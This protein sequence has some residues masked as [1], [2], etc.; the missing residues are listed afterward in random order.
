MFKKKRNAKITYSQL[1][2]NQE[3]V[4]IPLKNGWHVLWWWKG[5]DPYMYIKYRVCYNK[6]EITDVLAGAK[7]EM[8][9]ELKRDIQRGHYD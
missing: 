4:R 9:Q 5:D 7:L 1:P 3:R 2:D 8:E 6:E